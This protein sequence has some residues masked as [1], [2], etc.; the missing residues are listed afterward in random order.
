MLSVVIVV[1]HDLFK[2]VELVDL[3][4]H[5]VAPIEDRYTGRCHNELI[6]ITYKIRDLG[7][8]MSP[9][10]PEMISPYSLSLLIISSMKQISTILR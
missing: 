1:V 6:D 8:L 10:K 3:L 5:L 2:Q 7:M 9:A 4:G